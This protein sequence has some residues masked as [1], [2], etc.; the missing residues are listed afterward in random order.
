MLFSTRKE[1]D[2]MDI[3]KSRKKK[4]SA[5]CNMPLK[6]QSRTEFKEAK[7]VI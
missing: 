2:D 4:N 7:V 6:T 1:I 3:L 5:C